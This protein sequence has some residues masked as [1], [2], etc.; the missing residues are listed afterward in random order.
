MKYGFVLPDADVK[1]APE[2]AREAED[3][4]WDGVFI[5]DC[6]Y[7][8]TEG[9]HN[10]PAYDPWVVLAAMAVRT[11]RVIIGPMITPLSRRRP[12]KVARET[13]TLDILSNG[14]LVLP[15]GLGA[16]DDAG[17]ER[18]GEATGRKERAE[19]LDEALDIIAGLWS[20]ERF[21][22][23]GRHFQVRDLTFLPR[24]VQQPRIPVW[25]VAA[26]PREKSM[27]RALRWDGLLPNTMNHD[28]SF[29]ETTPE[30]VRAMR[31]YVQ[32][33]RT[34]G[35]PF[36]IIMEGAT[37]GDDP[38]RARA[39]VG[40]FEEAGATWWIESRWTG[41]NGPEEIRRRLRQG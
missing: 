11:G 32:E 33:R 22:F 30:D 24:P 1:I 2:L 4:G 38:A 16:L 9:F 8:D 18:V 21:S 35:G 12:W 6:I 39:T 19:L 26:W 17:F 14:R 3:A 25:V 28:G 40:P 29:R 13:A 36:D 27:A 41:P 7:I 15:V 20:G 5:P 31:A 34:E 23:E 10:M 37:P